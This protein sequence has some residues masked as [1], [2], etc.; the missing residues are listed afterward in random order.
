[1]KI[2]LNEYIAKTRGNPKTTDNKNFL[3]YIYDEEDFK[4][5]DYILYDPQKCQCMQILNG[6]KEVTESELEIHIKKNKGIHHKCLNAKS[7]ELSKLI[8]ELKFLRVYTETYLIETQGKNLEKISPTYKVGRVGL[9]RQ[10]GSDIFKILGIRN[11]EA[12]DNKVDKKLMGISKIFLIHKNI[13][14]ESEKV[15]STMEMINCPSYA[16]MLYN[17]HS[18]IDNRIPIITKLVI[19]TEIAKETIIK[20]LLHSIEIRKN[21]GMKIINFNNFKSME[22]NL[23]NFVEILLVEL[24]RTILSLIEEQYII[25]KTITFTNI[26]TH[27]YIE[28]IEKKNTDFYKT[29]PLIEIIKT[30]GRGIYKCGLSEGRQVITIPYFIDLTFN[31]NITK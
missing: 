12:W 16:S 17:Y 5:L 21:I 7:T 8:S 14:L 13:I 29:N 22:A 31:N 3:H 2:F 28:I 4:E 15:I 1:M 26:D 6:K 23:N 10:D 19:F 9:H 18:L 20:M 25:D 27:N 30:Y 24:K 11:W